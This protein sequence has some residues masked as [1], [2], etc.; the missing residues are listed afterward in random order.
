[1]ALASPACSR[2]CAASSARMPATACCPPTGASRTC[3][4]RSIPW[5]AWRWITCSTATVACARSRRHWPPPKRRTTVLPWRACI[6]NWTTP[7]VT[8]PMHGRASCWP[9]SAS[10]ASR[11]SAGSVISPAVGGC[12]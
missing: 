3:A 12:A 9:D 2:C 8:P 1:M 5:I 10:A 7:T 4:R 11:W 6:P